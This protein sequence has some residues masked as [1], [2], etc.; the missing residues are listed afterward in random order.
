MTE[1]APLPTSATAAGN[2]FGDHQEIPILFGLWCRA[3]KYQAP[4]DWPEDRKEKAYAAR[5]DDQE[6]LQ[7]SIARMAMLSEIGKSALIWIITREQAFQID[8]ANPVLPSE[9]F[10]EHRR[11]VLAIARAHPEL[12]RLAGCQAESLAEAPHDSP[13]LETA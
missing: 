13:A 3:V 7:R 1:A 5:G 11:L 12:A 10:P 2:A 8:R 4:A 6:R 9:K